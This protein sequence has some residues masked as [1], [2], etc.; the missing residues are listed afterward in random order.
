MRNFKQKF[1]TL[2][3]AVILLSGLM[4]ACGRK[5]DSGIGPD[6]IAFLAAY[7][8]VDFG[9]GYI[10][11]AVAHG[12]YFYYFSYEWLAE[13]M[14]GENKLM[15]VA[16]AEGTVSEVTL[17]PI[18]ENEHISGITMNA[19]GNFILLASAWSEN[20]NTFIIYEASPDGRKI[21]ETDIGE[22]LNIDQ[23][24]WIQQMFSDPDGNLYFIVSTNTGGTNL[25]SL[26]NDGA[27]KGRVEYDG[28]IQNL[29]FYENDIYL[30]AWGESSSGMVLRQVDF[31]TG[32]L[33]PEVK[34]EGLARWGNMNFA[35]GGETGLLISDGTSLFTGDME[36]GTVTKLLDWID[37]DILINN[38]RFFGQLT[39]GSFWLLN[40]IYG[41]DGTTS[42]LIVLEQT[43]YGELPPRQFITYGALN[44]SH[45]IRMAIINF[46]KAND[47]YRI[48]IKEYLN[49][50]DLTDDDDWQAAWEAAI[51]QFNTDLTSGRGPD[52]IDL[53][54]VNFSLLASKG[55]LYDLTSLIDKSDIDRGDYLENAINAYSQNGKIYGMMTGFMINTLV[56]H[57]SRLEGIERWD[58]NEM[59][60]WAEKHPESQLMNANAVM[61]LSTLISSNF[62]KF[63]DWNTGKCDF[64]GDEFIR[65]ME[66]AA[67]FG[68]D[69]DAWDW[70]NP[71]RIG[72]YEGISTGKYLLRDE[73]IYDLLFTMSMI[74]SL[75]D[76]EPKFI[77][78]PTDSGSGILMSP[79]GAVAINNRSKHK[80]GAYAFIYYLMSDTFQN[81]ENMGQRYSIP[82]KKS[83]VD[84][85]IRVATTVPPGQEDHMGTSGYDDFSVDISRERSKEFVDQFRDIINRAEGL[86]IY[87]NLI[88]NI[89]DEESKS[90]FS[91]Q[92]SAREAAE[93]IQN[94]IQVYV[95][96]NR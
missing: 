93:I 91:G 47:K 5:D 96:E 60:E 4:T 26:G 51:L 48:T 89:I 15:K 2:T 73:Y 71:D 57:A 6:T 80:D 54:N 77:G 29:L 76:G 74:N 95:N 40:E 94:R 65:I 42:E 20:G 25:L 18:G 9:T 22:K 86:R 85:M 62:D 3:L 43:T 24:A 66:F 84:E 46:N 63:V 69:S 37:S 92:K 79:S 39:N 88:Y 53:S 67:T 17:F 72:T 19:Q 90:F 13:E 8:D 44:L 68:D 58:I 31:T 78:Y 34:F 59:I 21:S 64:T 10:Q 33:G 81:A 36:N 61:V 83:A 14:R 1:I 28:W 45:D 32:S 23:G 87:D 30:T 70:S 41:Q 50:N 16:L 82:I 11:S 35:N 27:I 55:V 7:Q 38:V 12:D 56:G 49:F 75:F 52:I